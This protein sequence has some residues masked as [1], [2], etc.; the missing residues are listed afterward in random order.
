MPLFLSSPSE[1][2]IREYLEQQKSVEFSYRSIGVTRNSASCPGFTIDDHR[3]QIGVGEQCFQKAR[4]FIR[5]GHHLKLGWLTP[6]CFETPLYEGQTI[7]LVV[8][9][10]GI[11]VL[12]SCRVVYLLEEAGE[13]CRSGFAYGTLDGH[14]E[15]GEERFQVVWDRE[16]D[17][18]WFEI[19]AFSQ[20]NL[21]YSRLGYPF[22]RYMQFR[23]AT[24]SMNAVHRNAIN[25]TT[26]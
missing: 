11:R 15:C 19:A 6:F 13:I 4:D 3:R 20:P 2:A 25:Q 8:R 22:V 7:G 21:W 5:H 1:S 14:P 26:E 18:V 24:D 12:A 17:D 23:F 10:L 16:S 9:C